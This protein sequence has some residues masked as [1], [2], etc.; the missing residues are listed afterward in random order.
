M[1]RPPAHAAPENRLLASLPAPARARLKPHLQ[2]VQLERRE[3]LFRVHEP[4]RVAYFPVNAVVSFVSHLESGEQLEVGLVGHDGLVGTSV[5]PGITAMSC[6]GV[7]Q[8]PGLAYRLSADVLRREVLADQ[9][10][11]S[12]IGRFAQVL[13]VRSMQMS[14][15]NMFHSVEQRCVRWLLSIHDLAAAN[16]VPLTHELMATMLGAH[17]PTVTLVLRSL[18][19]AGLIDEGRGHVVLKD[20]AG[21]EAVCCECYGVMRDEQGGFSGGD[22]FAHGC[23]CLVI[24]H[25]DATDALRQLWGEL[26]SEGG[27]H[28]RAS[29]NPV[30]RRASR[31]RSRRVPRNARPTPDL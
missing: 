23:G 24:Q 16:D 14:V 12:A 31:P 6:D 8:I 19:K 25:T 1:T 15:C 18:H 3:T 5:F 20:R 21:L 4:L 9:S 30:Q 29:K 2:P 27:N 26:P 28:D 17:R 13:L 22:V 7:V 11:Y 10:L